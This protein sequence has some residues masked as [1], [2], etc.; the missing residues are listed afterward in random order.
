MGRIKTKLAKRKTNELM[1]KHGEQF[2][3]DFD[4][5]K[6]VVDRYTDVSSKKLRNVIA[7][8][9]TRLTRNQDDL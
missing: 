6:V 2:T 9:A 7:G 8:Y 1:K 4:K 5:N 3:E